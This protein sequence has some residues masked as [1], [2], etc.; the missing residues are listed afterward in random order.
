MAVNDSYTKPANGLAD[1]GDLIVDGSGAGTG[2]VNVT[3]I[4]ATGAS[5]I[6]REVDVDGDGTYEVSIKMD[7]KTGEWQSQGNDLLASQSQDI[8]LRINNTSGGVIDVYTAGYEV[9]N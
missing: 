6:Y 9:D 5:D 7:A 8:R 1:G 4:G 3:E 2:A